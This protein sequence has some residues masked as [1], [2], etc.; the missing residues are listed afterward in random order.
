MAELAKLRHGEFMI[1]GH[2]GVKKYILI[3]EDVNINAKVVE[4]I[5]KLWDLTPPNLFVQF[6]SGGAHPKNL[7]DDE[8]LKSDDFQALI[9]S[10]EACAGKGAND[11]QRQVKDT[12]NE[13]FHRKLLSV[14]DGIAN[15]IDQ[16]NSWIL[17]QGALG[18]CSTIEHLL[19]DALGLT[20][21]HP[22]IL[23][24]D[25]LHRNDYQPVK[26]AVC[27]P[28]EQGAM[29]IGL[30]VKTV[31]IPNIRE[32]AFWEKTPPQNFDPAT[33]GF[34]EF[35]KTGMA[36]WEWTRGD[37]NLGHPNNMSHPG[38]TCA[39]HFIFITT[40]APISGA[41]VALP[42]PQVFGSAG[43][44]YLSGGLASAQALQHS[45]MAGEPTLIIKHT[46]GVAHQNSIILGEVTNSCNANEHKAVENIMATIAK[47]LPDSG[48]FV[49]YSH[50]ATLVDVYAN[51]PGLFTDIIRVVDPLK[52]KPEDVLDILSKCMSSPEAG[53]PELGVGAA[54]QNVMLSAWEQHRKLLINAATQAWYANMVVVFMLAAGFL[55]TV[56][57]C[58]ESFMESEGKH[59]SA[60]V[61]RAVNISI[62]VLPAV[63]AVLVTILS[64]FRLMQKWGV[65]HFVASRIV[66]QIYLFR[67][68]APPYGLKAFVKDEAVG[69]SALLQKRA[70]M[71]FVEEMQ[72]MCSLVSTA[73]LDDDWLHDT[74]S[75]SLRLHVDMYV[76]QTET[77]R[78]PKTDARGDYTLLIDDT[79][80]DD[81]TSQLSAEEYVAR[82]VRPL[83]AKYQ[84]DAI[85]F[86]RRLHMSEAAIF[87]A[88]M[89]GTLLGALRYRIWVPV[90]IAFSALL[91][92]L[93]QHSNIAIRVSSVNA[94]IRELNNALTWWEALGVVEKR[95]PAVKERIC[96]LVEGM[97]EAQAAAWTQST[98]QFGSSEVD[99]DK[100]DGDTKKGGDGKAKPDTTSKQDA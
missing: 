49:K 8:I 35:K 68:R 80:E 87:V 45:I 1:E 73:A 51:R 48:H 99:A 93:L 100:A 12:V 92:A 56:L 43:S 72:K 21:A 63:A 85:S 18:R 16:T 55:A 74:P 24:A 89:M 6:L 64:R 11:N 5:L 23:G 95:T 94:C 15:A 86:A 20:G 4:A 50:V 9:A 75:Q 14:F 33:P 47:E 82:R 79:R 71:R 39:T 30:P 25:F 88:T 2:P 53:V 76:H 29:P 10:I 60:G 44:V 36:F 28:L 27:D 34:E 77:T 52:D 83:L 42:N 54:E 37:E 26:E 97:V 96:L 13:V 67:M 65:L 7:V 84:R 22:V 81:L 91:S 58:T 41:R 78:P 59:M 61:E 66:S 31:V 32:K 98:A 38:M 3:P 17:L 57:V 62:I 46:A 69:N 19:Q 70:R 90:S 40:S